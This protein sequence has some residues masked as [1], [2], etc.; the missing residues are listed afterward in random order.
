LAMISYQMCSPAAKLI[1]SYHNDIIRPGFAMPLLSPLLMKILYKAQAIVVTS[2]NL[3]NSSCV[4]KKFREKCIIIPHGID[5]GRFNITEQ[6]LEE[7]KEIRS[8]INKPIILFVGRLVYYKGLRYLIRAMKDIE[9][10]LIVIGDGEE[11]NKLKSFSKQQG[12]DNKILWLGN[13]PDELLPAYYHA[14]DLFVL[15]SCCN[16]ESFGLVILE[17][18][19]CCK[20]VVSTN[21][22]T[23]VTFTNLHQQTGLV[24]PPKNSAALA[25]AV[26]FLLGSKDLREAYGRAARVRA[27]REF[28]KEIMAQNFLTLYHTINNN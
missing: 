24:V 17:A 2:E 8:S 10:K 5:I 4:L 11:R 3:I 7:S 28:T 19:A 9:G 27:Q 12:V 23:G 20:P 6:V 26:N 22:S 15:P 18:H 1:V 16:S 25:E 21:L 13:I 14:C